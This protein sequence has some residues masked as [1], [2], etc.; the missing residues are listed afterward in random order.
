LSESAAEIKSVE[1]IFPKE[2]QINSGEARKVRNGSAIAAQHAMAH[3]LRIPSS[4]IIQSRAM[5]AWTCELAA[6]PNGQ[7]ASVAETASA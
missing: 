6:G 2:T 3:I 5:D 7:S 1:N 4:K